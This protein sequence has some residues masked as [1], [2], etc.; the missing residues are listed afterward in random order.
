[1]PA[2]RRG[3]RSGGVSRP[4]AGCAAAPRRRSSRG[5]G[6]PPAC[7][8]AAGCSTPAAASPAA[9]LQ[10]S[11][12]AI[13]PGRCGLRPPAQLQREERDTEREDGGWRI[14]DTQKDRGRREREQATV[15]P[16]ACEISIS[17]YHVVNPCHFTVWP[18]IRICVSVCIHPIPIHVFVSVQYSTKIVTQ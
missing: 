6:R 5:G 18:R 16:L 8:A 4:E 14:G 7:R 11:T 2:G 3:R 10:G 12:P 9:G 1:M 13:R 17:F 15:Y